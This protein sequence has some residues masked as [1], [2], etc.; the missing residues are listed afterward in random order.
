ME[1]KEALWKHQ[2]TKESREQKNKLSQVLES[3]TAEDVA[4]RSEKIFCLTD[5]S[6]LSI[7]KILFSVSRSSLSPER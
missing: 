6:T 2:S 5:S 7:K 3:V 1:K 4:D